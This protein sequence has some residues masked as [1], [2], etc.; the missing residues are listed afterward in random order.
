MNE[1]QQHVLYIIACAAGAAVQLYDHIPLLQADGWQVCVILTPSATGFVENERLTQLTGHPV[2]S[3]Y[4]RP[5]DPDVLP[6]ADALLV[7]P[8]TFNTINKWALGISDNL[9][10]GLLCEFTG[11]KVPILAVPVVRKGKLAEHPAFGRSLKLLEEYGVHIF[12]HPELY[13]P[14]NEVPGGML[15]SEVRKLKGDM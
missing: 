6:P 11:M 12:Y 2:R 13:P 8:A 10:L 9:A 5:G 15:V 7:F 14:R 1:E 3:S 4:K